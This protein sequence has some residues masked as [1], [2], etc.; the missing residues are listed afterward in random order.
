MLHSHLMSSKG[1]DKFVPVQNMEAFCGREGTGPLN[2]GTM[3][4]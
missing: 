2:L 3:W 4:M 1:K